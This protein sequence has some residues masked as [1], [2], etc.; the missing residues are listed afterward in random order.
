MNW[1]YTFENRIYT[2]VKTRVTKSLGT[3]YKNLT[4]T[5]D[6]EPSDPTNHFPTVLIHYLPF[7][8][9]GNTLDGLDINAME[10]TVQIDVASNKTQG[11]K[12]ARLVMWEVIDQFKALRYQ[13]ELSPE[14]INTGNDTYRV[15]ARMS[16]IV[17][18]NDIVG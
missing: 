4:F 9:I 10:S 15:V 5:M 3:T 8:E 13:V 18:A 11:Q 1:I 7:A 6:E 2:I 14:V 17:G 12:V 16:R